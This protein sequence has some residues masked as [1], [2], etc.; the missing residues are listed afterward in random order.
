MRCADRYSAIYEMQ[1]LN[2]YNI[3]NAINDQTWTWLLD[4]DWCRAHK[5]RASDQSLQQSTSDFTDPE[6]WPSKS[7]DFNVM[8]YCV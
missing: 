6:D 1:W 2:T 7:P 8:D 4:G 3:Q 5:A